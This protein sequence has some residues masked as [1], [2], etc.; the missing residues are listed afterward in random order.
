MA[1]PRPQILSGNPMDVDS[2]LADIRRLG[3]TIE[4]LKSIIMALNKNGVHIA[5]LIDPM[6]VIPPGTVN[7]S[8]FPSAG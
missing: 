3:D 5:V 7:S 6:R 8:R 2:A 1:D 4:E